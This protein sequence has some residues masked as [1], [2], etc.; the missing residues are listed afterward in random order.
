MNVPEIGLHNRKD[1]IL[2]MILE[3]GLDC[4][5]EIFR[6]PCGGVDHIEIRWILRAVSASLSGKPKEPK[7]KRVHEDY[8]IDSSRREAQRGL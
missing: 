4:G 8:G 3:K 7:Q 1:L 2:H 6:Q 5:E